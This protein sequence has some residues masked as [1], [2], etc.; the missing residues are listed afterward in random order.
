MGLL[1]LDKRYV[2]FD[3]LAKSKAS[4]ILVVVEFTK[5]CWVAEVGGDECRRRN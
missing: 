5:A 2:F 3:H 1:D 4:H